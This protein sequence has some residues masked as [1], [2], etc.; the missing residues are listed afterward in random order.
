M[1][2]LLSLFLIIFS[3]GLYAQQDTTSY[4]VVSDIVINGNNV[5]KDAIIFRE[6]TFE[7]GDTIPVQRWEEELRV[8]HENVQNTTLFNFVTFELQEDESQSNAVILNIDVVERW[9]VWVFPYVA[10]S[11][12]NLNAWYEA[13]DI[14]RFS[15]GV[16]MKYRN[17]LG[18]KHNIDFTFISGYNQNYGLSYDIPYMTGKQLFGFKFG[19][20][21][22]RDKEVPYITENNK[23]AYFNDDDKFAKQSAFV[24]VE[25]YCRLGHRNKFF[26]NFSY[27]N[28]LFHEGLSSLN[29][30]FTNAKGTRFQYFALMAT[31]KNDFRDEQ[32]YPLNGH[33]FELLMEKVG[34]VAFESSPDVFYAKITTDLYRPI[35]GR[36]YWASN[37]TMKMSPDADAPYFLNQGLGY[38][39]DYVRA[40]ELYVIDAM[41]FALVKNNLKYA[42]LN[43]VTRYIPFVKN[44]RFGKIHFALYANLFFDCA[45]S[46]KM[47]VNQSSF[48]DNK[49]IFG[50]GVGIDF[51]TYYDKVLRLEYGVNDMGKTGFFV[52]FVAPI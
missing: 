34:F 2:Q 47:T 43:P 49:F 6:L 12:R 21:Y 17:F 46:W 7:I 16:E 45:Y 5:T 13:D 11:D 48:L 29:S 14:R 44:E 38:K 3:F 28:T 24:F 35:K 42:I 10:Y 33:Y 18:L 39:N 4:V 32:N 41:N 50:T 37:L 36:W 51:V 31:Y 8:S 40:Y 22:K 20:G 30:D 15:Y 27:N 26:V 9:Y 25:P 52:H 23:I 1:K 19:G